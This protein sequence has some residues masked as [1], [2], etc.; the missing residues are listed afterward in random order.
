MK[1]WEG[2]DHSSLCTPRVTFSKSARLSTAL[3]MLSAVENTY[4]TGIV[5]RWIEKTRRKILQCGMLDQNDQRYRCKQS[6]FCTRCSYWKRSYPR[7]VRILKRLEKE[8]LEDLTFLRLRL[9]LGNSLDIKGRYELLKMLIGRLQRSNAGKYLAW[10]GLFDLADFQDNEH[11]QGFDVHIH[12]I[13]IGAA[14]HDDIVRTWKRLCSKY[15][16]GT[17][18]GLKKSIHIREVKER[19]KGSPRERISGYLPRVGIWFP[20]Y[21]KKVGIPDSIPDK[22]IQV[23]TS[24]TKGLRR[25]VQHNWRKR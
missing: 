2:G 4:S 23:Y 22:A 20:G 24:S 14:D 25:V 9:P 1:K 18:K 7:M 16:K 8:E 13:C 15:A 5:P 10:Y 11:G 3:R 12:F 6:T 19:K 17:F 21:I